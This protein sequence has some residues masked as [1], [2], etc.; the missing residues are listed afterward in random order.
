[1]SEPFASNAVD[2]VRRLV[3]ETAQQSDME[4]CRNWMSQPETFEQVFGGTLLWM[5]EYD[6]AAI[7]FEHGSWMIDS[8]SY[9]EKGDLYLVQRVTHADGGDLCLISKELMD[10][11]NGLREALYASEGFK[12]YSLA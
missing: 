9:F 5:G 10:V 12:C 8:C 11:T 2:A 1:M 4:L 3:V 7:L 6:P